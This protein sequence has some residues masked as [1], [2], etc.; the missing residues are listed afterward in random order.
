VVLLCAGVGLCM[1]WRDYHWFLDVVAGWALG[2][3]TLW[4]LARWTPRPGT[5]DAPSND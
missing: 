1:L 5:T 2:A 3:L 4:S